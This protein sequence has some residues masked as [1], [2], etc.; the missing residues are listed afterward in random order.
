[1]S[2]DFQY[3]KNKIKKIFYKFRNRSNLFKMYII[4][5]KPKTKNDKEFMRCF[6]SFSSKYEVNKRPNM[7]IWS[8]NFQ[9]LS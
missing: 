4:F 3:N 8:S 2:A 7:I 6:K 1:M 9:R 5:E